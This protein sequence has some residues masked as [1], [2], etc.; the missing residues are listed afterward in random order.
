M[1]PWRRKVD[2]TGREIRDVK[3]IQLRATVAVPNGKDVFADKPG[4]RPPPSLRHE[5]LTEHVLGDVRCYRQR[6]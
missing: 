3:P 1:L 4:R 6:G 5:A 2:D